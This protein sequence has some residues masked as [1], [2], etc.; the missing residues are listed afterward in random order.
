MLVSAY[1][2][3]LLNGVLPL[4]NQHRLISGYAELDRPDIDAINAIKQKEAELLALIQ[5][6]ETNV[7]GE[8]ARWL[9]IGKT[10]IQKGFMSL[11]RSVA[12]PTC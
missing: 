8:S 6:L 10:D 1:L 9:A 2:F 4:E 11:V 12:K 5:A 3:S 7:D